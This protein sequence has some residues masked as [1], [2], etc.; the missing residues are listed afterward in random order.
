MQAG[1]RIVAFSAV[2]GIVLLALTARPALAAD[3]DIKGLMGDNFGRVQK[4]LIELVTGNYKA[5]PHDVEVIRTHAIDMSK[6]L[7]D[8]AKTNRELFLSMAYNLQVHATNL[9]EI[10]RT[11]VKRDRET[12]AGQLLKID[13][14]R[15]SA[16]A[17][18]GNMVT[19]CVACHNQFRRRS[20]KVSK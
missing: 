8:I 11:L 16:A 13:Y 2:L 7:P 17:H 1:L 4:I 10:A 19:S 20:V 15:N 3:K 9:S 5:V 12:P 14:L 6:K 18:F